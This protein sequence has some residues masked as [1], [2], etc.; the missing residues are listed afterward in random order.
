MK[1]HILIL[2]VVLALG[3]SF[4]KNANAQGM[5]VGKNNFGI[6][7]GAGHNWYGSIGGFTPAFRVNFDHGTFNAGPGVISLGASAGFSHYTYDYGYYW[8]AYKATWNNFVIATRGA[9]HYNFGK[10]WNEKFNA[11]A[12]I[13]LGVRIETYSDNYNG[14]YAYDD[15]GYGGTNAHFATFVGGSYQATDNVGF[16]AEFGYDVTSAL[17]GVNFRF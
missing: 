12:G 15:G 10:I 13:G 17:V 14:A 16:F 6:G 4:S 11:Y 7:V 5:E 9:W 2:A 8:G 1:K 3:V